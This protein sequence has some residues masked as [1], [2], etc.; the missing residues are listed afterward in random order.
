[1]S[2]RRRLRAGIE[3]EVDG[4][5]VWL[6]VGSDAVIGFTLPKKYGGVDLITEPIPE[7]PVGLEGR[8][9]ALEDRHQALV[10]RVV[11][12]EPPRRA[13]PKTEQDAPGGDELSVEKVLEALECYSEPMPQ[14][15]HW[16]G[17]PYQVIV[18]TAARIIREQTAVIERMT[19]RLAEVL[20]APEVAT[21]EDVERVAEAIWPHKRDKWDVVGRR[22]YLS[23]ARR[24]LIAMGYEIEEG[25]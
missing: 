4:D 5:S 20:L 17:V 12:L 22:R 15:S 14:G 9:A 19:E 16:E 3:V 8:I 7:E 13:T 25:A 21:K 10:D 1:M 2:E 18:D 6:H 11:A 23:Y 24:A